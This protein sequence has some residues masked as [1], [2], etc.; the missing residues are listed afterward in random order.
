MTRMTDRWEDKISGLKHHLE[1]IAAGE[2]I[3]RAEPPTTAELWQSGKVDDAE[4]LRR[5]F[6]WL[7]GEAAEIRSE[8]PSRQSITAIVNWL[9]KLRPLRQNVNHG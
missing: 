8:G 1:L 5:E 2:R 7:P 9:V 6:G 4:M 3:L